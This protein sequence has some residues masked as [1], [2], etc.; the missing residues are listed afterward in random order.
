M[1]M[2][3]KL[4]AVVVIILASHALDCPVLWSVHR[5]RVW[6]YF[7][8]RADV[9]CGMGLGAAWAIVGHYYVVPTNPIPT[10]P[11]KPLKYF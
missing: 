11:N 9:T 4:Y 3:S 6:D 10:A 7:H 8:T 5:R 1:G 2:N